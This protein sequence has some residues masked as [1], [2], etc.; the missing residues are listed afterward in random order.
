MCAE[1]NINRI[2]AVKNISNQKIYTY[3]PEKW[4]GGVPFT[5]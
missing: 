4:G 5:G 3:E 1:Q 2:I